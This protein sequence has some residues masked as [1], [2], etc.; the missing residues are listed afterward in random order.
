M[1]R[2]FISYRRSDAAAEAGRIYDY[3]EGR[4]GRKAIFKDV[5]T[6]DAGDDFRE[7][8]NDAV[9][10]CQVLLAVIGKSWFQVTNEAGKRRLDN[11]ADWVRLEIETALRRKVRVIP[12]LLDGVAM[13]AVRDLPTALQPLAYRNAAR[14]RHDPD[15]RRDMDRVVGVIQRHFEGTSRTVAPTSSPRPRRPRPSMNST[16]VPL[17]DWANRISRRSLLQIFGFSGAGFISIFLGKELL[18]SGGVFSKANWQMPS[19]EPET[20][21]GTTAEFNVATVDVSE[22][23]IGIV[24]NRAEFVIED[25]GGGVTLDLIEIPDGTFVMGAPAS[26]DG[27][28]ED[29]GPQHNVSVPS[30]WMGKYPVTQAQWRAVAALPK[31]EQDLNPS[32]AHFPGDQRP[33]ENV[34]WLDAVEFCQ[35]LS[36]KSGQRYRLPSEAEWEYACRAGP[37]TPFHIGETLTADLAN[38]DAT[39][40]YGGGPKGDYRQETT[41]V[42]SFPANANGLYDMHGNVWEWC[43][44]HWHNS[45]EGAPSDGS[46][47]LTDDWDFPRLLRGGSWILYPRDCRS[48]CR[49]NST[50]ELRV[51]IIGFRVSCA[52][53]RTP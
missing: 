33:V 50:P 48:A 30:F 39:K 3:L 6:I 32:P 18:E 14:V 1:S 8:L 23:S 13:P 19:L 44:D 27:R 43:A 26:E 35:R 29:E 21:D 31:V 20:I 34:S 36:V 46:A 42:G 11:P 37:T 53:P 22:K 24:R 28:S 45:Y 17:K 12:I 15:F 2:I 52:A 51:N 47:W 10:Q 7:R 49:F 25:L 40:I 38:Y 9:G 5:D 4:F 41:V 16:A